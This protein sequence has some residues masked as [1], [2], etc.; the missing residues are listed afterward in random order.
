MVKE[1]EQPPKVDNAGTQT[2]G[3]SI[4]TIQLGGIG[5]DRQHVRGFTMTRVDL[6]GIV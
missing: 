2:Q 5:I 4:G 6:G 1:K 3:N